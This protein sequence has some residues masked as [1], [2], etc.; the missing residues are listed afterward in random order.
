MSAITGSI[1][2]VILTALGALHVYWALGGRAG[3]SATVPTQDAK[4]LFTPGPLATIAVA[5]GLFGM[6]AILAIRIG[7]IAQS[8]IPT[9]VISAAAWCIVTVFAL[10]AIG[11]FRF[12][13]FFKRTRDTRFARLDTIL[14]SPLCAAL[15]LL[16]FATQTL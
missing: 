7:W 8:A 13:G 2:I 3:K 5:L 12:V 16:T 6:A 14:Y 1:A 11:D 9:Y 10:R 4:P 15:A